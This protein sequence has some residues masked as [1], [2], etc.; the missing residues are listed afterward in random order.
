MTKE[1]KTFSPLPLAVL[2]VAP[3]ADPCQG[4]AEQRSPLHLIQ[5]YDADQHQHPDQHQHTDQHHHADQQSTSI[6]TIKYQHDDQHQHQQCNN[7]DD[8]EPSGRCPDLADHKQQTQQPS[9]PQPL[10]NIVVVMLKLVFHPH[11]LL[12]NVL[13]H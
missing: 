13:C 8:Q 2:R 3:S 12:C 1:E 7:G 4:R 11:A 9:R 10:V 6:S 5:V